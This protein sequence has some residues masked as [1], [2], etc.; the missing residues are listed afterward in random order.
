M[1]RTPLFS[2]HVA[3]KAKIVPFSGWDMPVQYEGILAEYDHTRRDVTVFDTS[4]MGEF[5]VEGDLLSSGLDRLV[6]QRLSDL[7]IGACRYGFLL[8]ENGGVLDDLIVFRVEKDRWF[9]VVNAG[10][11]EN[12]AKHFEQN[13]T[14]SARFTNIS[15][16][17]AKLDV[18][19]PRS[20]ELL[21]TIIPG[22]E[23]LSYY[24]FAEFPV[25][26]ERV[27]VSR[28]GYTGE[29]GYEIY[30]PWDKVGGLWQKI[31]ALGAKPAGLGARDILRLEVCYPLYGHELSETISPL[32]A[33][34]GVFIDWTKDFI[35]KNAL[36]K[37]QQSG[38]KRQAVAFT[39]GSRRSPR[40]GQKI[41]SPGQ[42]VIGE[43]TSG[44]FS[45][46]LTRGIGM[47]LID[48]GQKEKGAQIFFGDAAP[49]TIAEIIKKPFYKNGTLKS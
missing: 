10:T 29:L 11:M 45:P 24:T 21:S 34:L 26:G 2:E 42:E 17:T 19:G 36:Q 38:I 15:R 41:F 9:I 47:A 23:K 46:S 25:M 44:S 39:A 14:P 18:Q 13:I 48:A 28:T 1:L 49:G 40:A 7:A 27:I 43:V 5:I 30:F 4:H 12:D 3:L 20:R 35:G 37:Q 33:G 22:V 16:E 6:T 31:L 8:N 32:E